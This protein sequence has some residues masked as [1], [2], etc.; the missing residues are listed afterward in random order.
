MQTFHSF[1]LAPEVLS[2]LDTLGFVTPTAIQLQAIPALLAAPKVDMH[3]QAQTGT[4]KTL[5]FGLPLIHRVDQTQK[6]TQGLIVAPTRELAVQIC[7]SIAPFARARGMSI[8]VIYGG[9]S[10]EDQIRALKRGAQI[11]VG[12]PGRLNDHL[13]RGTLNLDAVSTLILD[14]ADIMLEMG[15]R[16]EVD[17][18]I[19]ECPHDREIWLFSATVKSGIDALMKEHMDNPIRLRASGKNEVTTG[20]TAQFYALV[21]HKSRIEALCRFIEAT[22]DFYGFVFCQ[23]KMTT[24]DVAEALI[25]R[26]YRAGAMHGDMSQ[27]ARNAMIKK[28]KSQ[29]ISIVVATDVAARGIDVANLT[30]VI[31]FSFPEDYESYVHRIGRTGRAGKEGIAIT[32]ITNREIRDIGTISNKYKLTINPIA[33]PSRDALVHKRVAQAQTLVEKLDR[34]A[35]EQSPMREIVEKLSP[36][37]TKLLAQFLLDEKFLSNLPTIQELPLAS[38]TSAEHADGEDGPQEL[39]LTAGLADGLTREDVIEYLTSTNVVTADEIRKVRLIKQRT[40]IHVPDEK[41]QPLMDSLRGA[42]CAGRKVHLS[43]VR[44]MSSGNGGGN[45]QRNRGRFSKR[46]DFGGREDRP[47][48]SFSSEGGSFGGES[49]G[50]F[51]GERSGSFGGERGERRGGFRRG[52]SRGGFSKRRDFGGRSS[53]FGSN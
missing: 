17:E 15:F 22:D 10:M 51:G 6:H 50:S 16:E 42:T 29:T 13:R 5:A 52:G 46:R 44:E 40:F 39:F 3:G 8:E 12:T 31:N 14:E 4:G 34:T 11:V 30:H 1:S 38:K 2:T 24:A 7:E 26:G 20:S 25:R 28:F 19:A 48:R 9:V 41:I 36:E 43:I 53:G 21:P 27:G 18:I 49:N 35:A 32:F 47:R 23:T 33:V 45:R 37:D